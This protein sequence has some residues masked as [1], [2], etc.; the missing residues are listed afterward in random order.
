MIIGLA[1]FA[2]SGKDAAAKFLVEHHEFARLAFA[3]KLKDLVLEINPEVSTGEVVHGILMPTVIRIE[4]VVNHLGWDEAKKLP[5]VRSLLQ[6]FGEGCRAV[7]GEDVWIEALD[8][9]HW[10]MLDDAQFN[11]EYFDCATRAVFTDVRYP[12]RKASCRERVQSHVG[13]A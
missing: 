11:E 3:D 9:E 7:L 1:G 10:A 12:D 13:V 8:K 5:D 4:D 6:T 2:G